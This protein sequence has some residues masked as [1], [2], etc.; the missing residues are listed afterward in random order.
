MKLITAIIQPA[1]QAN[2]EIALAEYGIKGMT[3]SEVAGF[4]RQRG[5]T[6]MYRGAEFTIDFIAKVRI[7]IL[8]AD[9]EVDAII[10]TICTA[11]KTDVVGDGK[12]WAMP[13]EDVVRIRTGER[14]EKAL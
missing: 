6:E 12:V 1:A 14:G 9:S 5:H 8:A 4:G 13:V 2:V 7:E 10:D 3:V 11:A